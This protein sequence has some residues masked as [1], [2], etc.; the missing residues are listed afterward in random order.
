MI[1]MIII[2]FGFTIGCCRPGRGIVN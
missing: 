2:I 1:I